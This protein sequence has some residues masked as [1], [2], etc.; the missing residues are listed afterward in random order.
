MKKKKWL[1]IALVISSAVVIP[2]LINN[3]YA[4]KIL[5]GECMTPVVM[6]GDIG[7]YRKGAGDIRV[8]DIICFKINITNK[9]VVLNHRVV[10]IEEKT[11]LIFRTKGDIN[12]NI[13]PWKI[14]IDQIIGELVFVIPT[15]VLLQPYIPTV[16]MLILIS[17]M[18]IGVIYNNYQEKKMKAQGS[19]ATGAFLF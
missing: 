9:I 3:Y 12:E 19:P 11:T 13:D 14:T 16:T 8:G 10:K 17:V 1:G 7:V 15:H 6:H 18:S 5:V 2:F 4:F